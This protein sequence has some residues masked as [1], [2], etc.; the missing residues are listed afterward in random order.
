MRILILLTKTSVQD[1]ASLP[2]SL[3]WATDETSVVCDSCKN[4]IRPH[5]TQLGRDTNFQA[6][7]EKS[8]SFPSLETSQGVKERSRQGRKTNR[9]KKKEFHKIIRGR[10]H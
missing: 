3:A 8:V 7:K 2:K 1:E 4:N 10:L 9:R 6:D 5:L